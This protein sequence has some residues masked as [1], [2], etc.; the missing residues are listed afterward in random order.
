MNDHTDKPNW[1]Y[2]AVDNQTERGYGKMSYTRCRQ[3]RL[4]F[5]SHTWILSS[6]YIGALSALLISTEIKQ[7]IPVT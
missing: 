7:H 5:A 4:G 3:L 6:A 1:L 2:A